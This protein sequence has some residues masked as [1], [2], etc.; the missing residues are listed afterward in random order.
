VKKSILSSR[1]AFFY[2]FEEAVT[3]DGRRP[4]SRQWRRRYLLGNS[5]AFAGASR[6]TIGLAASSA[7][8]D[9]RDSITG[10]QNFPT[11]FLIARRSRKRKGLPSRRMHTEKVVPKKHTVKIVKTV[12]GKT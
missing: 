7:D 5:S 6:C 4:G 2:M 9:R 3:A 10:G 11:R 12:K 8:A 1:R